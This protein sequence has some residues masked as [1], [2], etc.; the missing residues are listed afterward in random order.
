MLNFNA[1][2]LL[3]TTI[4][5]DFILT[6][7]DSWIV[8]FQVTGSIINLSKLLVQGLKGLVR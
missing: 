6:S 2:Q 5:R 3:I 7:C 4:S 1:N 8:I